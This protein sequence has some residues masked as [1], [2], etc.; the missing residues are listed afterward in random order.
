MLPRNSIS[1]YGYS[2]N[3]LMA[4]TKSKLGFRIS[5]GAIRDLPCQIE[6]AARLG[7]EMAELFC[8]RFGLGQTIELEIVLQ[9]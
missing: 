1:V 5:L 6:D 2:E 9:L 8:Q 3:D 4:F 7:K